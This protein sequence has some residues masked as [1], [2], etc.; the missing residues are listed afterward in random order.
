VAVEGE[1][2]RRE[3]V[4]IKALKVGEK[5]GEASTTSKGF[6]NRGRARSPDFSDLQPGI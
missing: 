5:C 1:D 4:K 3:K 6:Q 2:G